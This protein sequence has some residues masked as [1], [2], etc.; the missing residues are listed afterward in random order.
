MTLPIHP[1]AFLKN[2]FLKGYLFVCLFLAVLGLLLHL[3][4]L[5]LGCVGFSLQ[6]LV[7]VWIMGSG[8]V[9]FSSCSMQALG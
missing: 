9:G 8:G 3:G 6:W 7:L 1:S 5:W 2:N 4:F